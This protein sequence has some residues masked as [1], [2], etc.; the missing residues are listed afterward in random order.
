MSLRLK[1]DHVK[2]Y[3]QE[4]TA[5][6]AMAAKDIYFQEE[7]MIA[8]YK[9]S[10]ALKEGNKIISCGNGGSMCDSLHFA[11]ELTGKYKNHRDPL[12]AIALSDI[13]AMS[14]IA[15]DYEYNNVFSRQVRGLGKKGDVLL[16]IST[17]GKSSNVIKAMSDASTLS[18]QVVGLTGDNPTQDF[19]DY[20]NVLIKVPSN[21]TNHIQELHIKIIHI[22]VEIIEKEMV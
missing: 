19:K 15:N 3:F 11:S 10:Q 20:C 16:A 4:A 1:I 22:L 5:L 14:C 13:A 8:G 9:M 7:I 18:M 21:V 17:S 2:A 12:P 6:S